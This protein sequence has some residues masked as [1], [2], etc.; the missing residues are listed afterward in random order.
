M[1]QLYKKVTALMIVCRISAHKL[2]LTH[3]IWKLKMPNI[4][5]LHPA[6]TKVI[7]T[8]PLLSDRSTP[9]DNVDIVGWGRGRVDLT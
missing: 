1:H 2:D 9:N 5:L 4:C 7:Q 6:Q 3:Q 8:L